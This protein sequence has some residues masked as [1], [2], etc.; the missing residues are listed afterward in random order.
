MTVT[1]F[2]HGISSFGV[3]V[4]PGMEW[5]IGIGNV[6]W[7]VAAKESTNLWYDNLREKVDDDHIFATLQEAHDACTSGQSDTIFVP[8]VSI[9]QPHRQILPRTIS[10]MWALVARTIL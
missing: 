1:R 7:I 6:Y 2:P 9:R 4:V 8:L 10:T 3:P 5:G